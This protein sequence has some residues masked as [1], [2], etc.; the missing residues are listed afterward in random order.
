MAT[1]PSKYMT[2][3][4]YDLATYV[5]EIKKQYTDQ[6][7]E[8]TLMV[9]IYGMMGEL[10]SNI[11]Q[12]TIV[13]ASEFANESIP[14]KAKFEKNII[15]HALN[16]N[17][18]S[19]T[20]N[21]ATM[22]V[23]LTFIE[24]EIIDA[25]G[26]DGTGI[27]KFDCDNKIYFGEYEFHPDYDINIKRVK[28]SDGTYT[29][30]A[31]YDMLDSD[32]YENP[33]SDITNPYLTPPVVMNVRGTNYL[34]TTC[35]LRQV[36]KKKV[37]DR[38]LSDDTIS[39]K[40]AVFSFESQLAAFTVDVTEMDETVHLVPIYE[41]LVNSNSKYQYIWYTYLDTDKIRIK[42]DNLNSYSPRLNSNLEITIYTTQGDAGNFTWSS[43]KYPIFF[44]D[45]E[46]NGY[47]NI[48]TQV[49]PITNQSLYGSNK[50]DIDEL[51]RVI[52]IEALAR[53]SITNNKDLQNY[54]NALDTD[55]SRMYFYKKR[56]NALERLYYSYIV[57]KDQYANVIPTNT[58]DLRL[59]PKMLV[60]PTET[61][62]NLIF[63]RGQVLSLSYN[64]TY[65]FVEDPDIL[66]DD[67]FKY[68]I[69]YNICINL[70]PMYVMYFISTMNVNKNLEF[71][72]INEKCLYQFIST[73]ININR[74]YLD[75]EDGC[76]YIRM[77]LEQNIM[78]D[79]VMMGTDPE[80]GEDYCNLR[81]FLVLY[82]KEGNPSSWCEAEL[83]DYNTEANIFN[84]L[85][86]FKSDDII[87]TKNRIH[88]TDVYQARNTS[89]DI[90]YGYLPANTK[91]MI[92]VVTKTIK[93]QN[94]EDDPATRKN[95]T[96]VDRMNIKDDLN[97]IIPKI[98]QDWGEDW[99]VVNSYNV[100]SG[101]DLFYDYSE[102]V[103][104]TAN[105]VKATA[106]DYDRTIGRNI[107]DIET[108]DENSYIV[109]MYLG[110]II[111][112]RDKIAHTEGTDFS[113]Y[114]DTPV[115]TYKDPNKYYNTKPEE[116]ISA[117][118]FEYIYVIQ[119]VP[120]IKYDYFKTEEMV[121]EFFNELIRR[122]YYIDNALE[123]IEDNFGMNFK[124]FNTYGPSRL[125]T[126]D[127]NTGYLDRVNISLNFRVS[128]QPNYDENIIQYMT[129]D[130][131]TYIDQI[132]SIT[133]IHISNL[134]TQITNTYKDSL[135]FFEFIG[136]NDY[137]PS[138]QHLF[139]MPMPD[140]VITPELVNINTLDDYKP[141]ITIT[142]V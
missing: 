87:D 94:D 142:I 48:T 119:D 105:A 129:D 5:N 67:K 45:S 75:N 65:T 141:D 86:T 22:D 138:E 28:L 38:I 35:K 16:L 81:V 137:G 4:I 6:V 115:L 42:F 130:I 63:K 116:D 124:F 12:N 118:P 71:S 97:L 59:D 19:F 52:A 64:H 72:Y 55:L 123:K 33:L 140:R 95:K 125:F 17:I 47:S 139:A 135:T 83:E 106:V 92:H 113:I 7:D 79:Q 61:S 121:E 8:D 36:E 69:P 41:G 100:I 107:D 112:P 108:D 24:D 103:Y 98:S 21:P 14:T 128:L 132:N 133:D 18:N 91:A 30:T 84:Y 51:R 23:F 99:C 53:G 37:Y 29:Y 96:Y 40:T 44:F 49:R 13:M 111:T 73:Y 127:N 90:D 26:H 27:F 126:L 25:I 31:M 58:I 34:F 110:D 117:N 60:R 2:P 56:D 104:S 46:R 109:K 89:M 9:G 134:I 57:M 54:F 122:K 43:T 82:N 77:G 62:M 80:T 20:A 3:D 93:S 131:K 68:I 32:V 50:M 39:F 88:I 101:I 11:A 114:F 120:M 10:F 136:I 102:I 85:F 70:E 15:S 1:D 66:S 78:A 76:Y 74:P